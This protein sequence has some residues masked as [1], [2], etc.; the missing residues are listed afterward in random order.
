VTRSAATRL[1]E[2][3]RD[4]ATE[5]AKQLKGATR[6]TGDEATAALHRSSDVIMRAAQ[7]LGQDLRTRAGSS[8]TRAMQASRSHPVATAALIGAGAAVITYL[9]TRRQ[10]DL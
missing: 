1:N 8:T 6:R 9:A 7:R 2:D 3:L 4:I 10:P 5:T